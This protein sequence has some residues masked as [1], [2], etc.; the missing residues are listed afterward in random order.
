MNHVH[1]VSPDVSASRAFYESFFGYRLDAQ[2]GDGVFLVDAKGFLL[3]ISPCD[4]NDIPA[5]PDWFHLGFCLDSAAAVHAVYAALVAAEVAIVKELRVF[6][7]DAV[8]FYCS[9]PGGFR[10]EVSWHADA[11]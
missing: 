1:L 9:D 4:P 6:G 3:A 5:F 7:E 11:A 10:L 2:H 8:N